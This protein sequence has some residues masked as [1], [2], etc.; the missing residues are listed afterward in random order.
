MVCFKLNIDNGLGKH[1][2][3]I[4]AADYQHLLKINFMLAIFYT[5]GLP[6]VKISF[7][8][9]LLR[10]FTVASIKVLLLTLA[11]FEFVMMVASVILSLNRC[12]PIKAIWGTPWDGNGCLSRKTQRGWFYTTSCP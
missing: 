5:V 12:H 9:S 8:C 7:I 6:V 1:M 10:I 2:I 3:D 4:P 11:S